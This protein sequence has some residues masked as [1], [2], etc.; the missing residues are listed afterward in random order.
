MKTIKGDLLKLAEEGR[1]DVI[2]HGC[3]C[4]C[5]MGGGIAAQIARKWPDVYKEDYLTEEGDESKL[6]TYTYANVFREDGTSFCVCN[7]YTQY[8]PGRDVCYEAI[9]EAFRRV[10]KDLLGLVRIGYPKIGAGIAGGDWDVISAII[11]EELA[12]C[13]HM[14]V[15]YDPTA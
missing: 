10:R 9:R 14:L 1:F 15:E 5:A 13:D 7:V 6:G 8:Y 2:V 3:N 11:D 12:G 4:F